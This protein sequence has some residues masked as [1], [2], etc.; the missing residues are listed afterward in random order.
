MLPEYGNICKNVFSFYEVCFH[1]G[2]FC[3]RFTSAVSINIDDM[4]YLKSLIFLEKAYLTNK[5]QTLNYNIFIPL[6]K[7]EHKTQIL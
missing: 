6:S 4:F 1:F 3:R 7:D 5:V 2:L